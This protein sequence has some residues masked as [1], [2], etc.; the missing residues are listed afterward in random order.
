[1]ALIEVEK[2]ERNDI[3][4]FLRRLREGRLEEGD[5][6]EEEETEVG[7]V[8]ESVAIFTSSLGSSVEGIDTVPCSK[9]LTTFKEQFT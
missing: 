8:E 4:C 7:V 3:L 2:R 1:L 5:I 9:R 6:V